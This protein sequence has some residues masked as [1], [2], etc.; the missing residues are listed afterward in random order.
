MIK[1]LFEQHGFPLDRVFVDKTLIPFPNA[2]YAVAWPIR[3]LIFITKY[4]LEDFTPEQVL[5]VIGHEL[6]H[7]VHF[8]MHEREIYILL[9]S[10]LV[11]TLSCYLLFKKSVYEAF[12]FTDP[13]PSTHEIPMEKRQPDR[14]AIYSKV[15]PCID[16]HTL[17][18]Y[19]TLHHS[20]TPS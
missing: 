9:A 20:S 4:M 14:Q 2:A 1:P 7:G 15:D 3:E 12:G 18:L 19:T 10:A 16:C 8:H 5:G 17:A 13:E 11:A 6:G